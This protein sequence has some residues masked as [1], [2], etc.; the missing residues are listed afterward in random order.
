MANYRKCKWQGLGYF[1]KNGAVKCIC[2]KTGE[3]HYKSYCAKKCKDY[4]PIK[5]T[6]EKENDNI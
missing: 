5:Q 1:G 2:D 6:K 3:A 4:E